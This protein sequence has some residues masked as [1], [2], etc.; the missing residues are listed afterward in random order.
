MM[1][2]LHQIKSH[3]IAGLSFILAPIAL[4]I[5]YWG[6]LSDWS[7]KFDLNHTLSDTQWWQITNLLQGD[8][9]LGTHGL[10]GDA[11]FNDRGEVIAYWLPFP[12][13][14]RL[15]LMSFFFPLIEI[16]RKHE[17]GNGFGQ[18]YMSIPSVVLAY[19]VTMLAL[20]FLLSELYI[21]VKGINNRK[22]TLSFRTQLI[23]IL[24]VPS[25]FFFRW[26]NVYVESI[27]W[28]I[29]ISLW[30]MVYFLKCQRDASAINY[31]TF[32][33]LVFFSFFTR[34][35][36]ILISISLVIF[37][38]F[39]SKQNVNAN[40]NLTLKKFLPMLSLC[41][42]ALAL[43]LIN[44]A[45]WGSPF[46]FV[47]LE[48]HI[49]T[50]SDPIRLERYMTY[51]NFYPKRF[52]TNLMY[53]WSFDTQNF[54]TSFPWVRLSGVNNFLGSLNTMDYVEKKI[55]VFPVMFAM[56]TIIMYFTLQKLR[57]LNLKYWKL[58]LMKLLDSP[59]ESSSLLGLSI[60]L[61]APALAVRYTSEW[62][63]FLAP[64]SLRLLCEALYSRNHGDA[65]ISGHVKVD[66]ERKFLWI[67][68]L[69]ITQFCLCILTAGINIYG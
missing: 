67:V 3:P 43:G 61:F 19:F 20:L 27:S 46:T 44:I 30:I 22:I 13:I 25:W 62:L 38:Y 28:A 39:H 34:I 41:S 58:W 36:E 57:N 11:M 17:I 2:F 55:T 48:K 65:V 51:G 52:L 40:A 26:A 53:Y 63:L 66:V 1:S 29:A 69:F 60:L 12:G 15:I 4:S 50:F 54:S 35:P 18:L 68:P 47:P 10:A 8:A 59:L 14:I 16:L 45:R 49:A 6:Q 7:F 24:T 64:F 23:V 31:V 32:S 5:L 56:I 33:I 42:G 9:T 21:K 37:L